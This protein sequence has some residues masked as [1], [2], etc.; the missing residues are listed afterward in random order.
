MGEAATLSSTQ[1][2]YLEAIG[3][4]VALT[5]AARVRDISS[6]LSV[7]KSTVT[8]ALRMLSDKKLVNY[9]PYE[10]VTLTK[11]GEKRA[12]VVERR[13]RIISRFLTEVLGVK[14]GEADENACR[15]EHA[16]AAGVLE[17]LLAFMTFIERCPRAEVKWREG[18]AQFCRETPGGE[19]CA[20]CIEACM[21]EFNARS[22]S[23]D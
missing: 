1:E 9:T 6:A 21:E 17:R 4:L 18:E 10:V 3:R 2:D 8:A 23:S 5:G 15:M 20:Q 22:R 14:K 12:H 16:I 13:H 19:S 11:R 7:H